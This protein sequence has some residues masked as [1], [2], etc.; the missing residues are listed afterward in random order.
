[1]EKTFRKIQC[2]CRAGISC[3][4][5]VG[6]SNGGGFKA[7]SVRS[8]RKGFPSDFL[9]FEVMDAVMNRNIRFNTMDEAEQYV[10]S[11]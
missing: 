5:T 2:K 9:P 6:K 7:L 8:A 4:W 10:R 1:M 3:R 11:L